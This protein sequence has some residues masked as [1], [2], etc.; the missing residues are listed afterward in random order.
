MKQETVYSMISHKGMSYI[1]ER[2]IPEPNTG[3]WIWLQ[4][5]TTHGYGRFNLKKSGKVL[6]A[7]NSNRMAWMLANKVPIP[8]GL[9]VCHRCDT[10]C[11][12][13]PDHLFLGTNMENY[14][15]SVSKGRAAWQN[16][17]AF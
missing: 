17:P 15:D 2:S 6:L 9:Q 14:L 13:N 10:R 8:E 11:C 3:C 4:S 16:L 1:E 5:L 7:I 12:V